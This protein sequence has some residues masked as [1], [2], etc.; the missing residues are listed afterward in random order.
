[1]KKEKQSKPKSDNDLRIEET[2]Y[3]FKDINV[4]VA[5]LY[6]NKTERKWALYLHNKYGEKMKAIVAFLPTYNKGLKSKFGLVIKPSHLVD[7]LQAV[8]QAKTKLDS[9]LRYELQ[10]AEV[11]KK[12]KEDLLALEKERDLYTKE[13]KEEMRKKR[14]E[15]MLKL[16]KGF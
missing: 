4:G 15:E 16:I 2:I 3:L 14:R 6:G 5:K 10:K 11:D 8:V 13:Q 12:E 9:Q 7:H 1:M